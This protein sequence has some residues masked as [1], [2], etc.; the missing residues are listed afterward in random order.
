MLVQ[1]AYTVEAIWL[2]LLLS[3][4]LACARAA[5][6]V[7][8]SLLHN[9]WSSEKLTSRDIVIVWW[10]GLM[11]GAVSVALVYY[12]FDDNPNSPDIDEQR[13][14]LI[15]ATLLVGNKGHACCCITGTGRVPDH[16]TYKL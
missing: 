16:A 13:A 5:F 8:F 10:S 14:T 6:V 7:P 11:R 4:L 2:V 12:H 3:A 1:N 9:I 15:A